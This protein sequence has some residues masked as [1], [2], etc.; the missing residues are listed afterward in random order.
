M[1]RVLHFSDV[2]V[3]VPL[4]AVPL[5]D[6]AGKRLLG[7]ANLVL[8][9]DRLFADAPAKLAALARFADEAAVDL[10]VCTGDYTGLGTREELA[11]AR[12]AVAPLTKR[13]LG[14]VTVPG[15]HDLYVPDAV[16]EHRFEDAFGDLVTSDLPE[17]AVR[18]PFPTVRFVGDA[19]AV[20]G[21]TSARPN[22]QPWRSSGLVGDAQLDA[23]RRALREPRV[24]AR[25]VVVATHY[26]P[27]RED[28]ARD[29]R[30]H[31][32]DDADALLALLREELPRGLLVH[33]HVH[34]RYH[35]RVPGGTAWIFNSGSATHRG[36]EGAWVY[37][38]GVSAPRAV[39]V[40]WDGAR[41]A[42]KEEGAVAL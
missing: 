29:T 10:A 7:A 34:H 13:P 5:R 9:R 25:Y 37:D 23:L 17:L 6:L 15:N 20:I 22:P 4:G 1:T 3:G 30:L 26:A 33:G 28:G 39:P 35:Q 31:G 19:L 27:L 2:H 41:Y 32:L 40:D 11:A 8:H 24:R 12:E 38:L 14:F 42:M 16:R 18:G 36:R 21:V